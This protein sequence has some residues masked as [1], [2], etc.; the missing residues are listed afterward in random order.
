MFDRLVI[1]DEQG[2]S[3][4]SPREV[5]QQQALA[6]VVPAGGAEAK[7]LARASNDG[8][9]PLACRARW[10]WRQNGR[11]GVDS[12]PGEMVLTAPGRDGVG[13]KRV[14]TVIVRKGRCHADDGQFD[15]WRDGD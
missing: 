14:E 6:P 4:A 12:Q 3:P 13:I 8:T 5:R 2:T 9:Q 7:V 1:A 10:C 11:D 15:R